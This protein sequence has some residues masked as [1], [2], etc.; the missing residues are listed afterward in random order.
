MHSYNRETEDKDK[1]KGRMIEKRCREGWVS[2]WVYSVHT[3]VCVG[4]YM[5]LKSDKKFDVEA[6]YFYLDK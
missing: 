6:N 5:M 3:R 2:E 1:T 4:E